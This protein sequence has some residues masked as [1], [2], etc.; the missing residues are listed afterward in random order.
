MINNSPQEPRNLNWPLFELL[1]LLPEIF[2]IQLKVKSIVVGQ[3]RL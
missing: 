3:K 2:K 1:F